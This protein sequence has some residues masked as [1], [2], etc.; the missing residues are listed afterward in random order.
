VPAKRTVADG[1]DGGLGP[2][3]VWASGVG[4]LMCEEVRTPGGERVRRV[5]TG[6]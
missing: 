1:A 3:L 5:D 4:W 6:G 2:S